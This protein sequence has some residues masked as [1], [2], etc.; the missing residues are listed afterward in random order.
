MTNTSLAGERLLLKVDG[1]NTYDIIS[2]FYNSKAEIK[3]LWKILGSIKGR[4][5]AGE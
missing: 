2:Y 5:G 4:M 3:I 1:S